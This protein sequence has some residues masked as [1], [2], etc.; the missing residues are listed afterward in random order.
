MKIP[1]HIKSM[2]VHTIVAGEHYTTRRREVIKTLLGSCVA[3]CLFDPK[4]R[5]IGMNHF[6][7][8]ADRV[9]QGDMMSSRSGFYGI[10]AME[11]LINAMLK[12]NAQRQFLQAKVFGAGSVL[13]PTD[14][15][16]AQYD[17]GRINAEFVAEFLHRE[18]IPMVVRD[19][20]GTQG[21][22]I[23]FDATDFSVYRSLIDPSQAQTVR[24]AEAQL[25]QRT[26]TQVKQEATQVLF[27]NEDEP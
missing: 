26:E 11:L 16:A 18:R 7:L 4:S 19:V 5:V 8:P 20:G 9:R 2:T 22:V 23:Y 1:E 3:V 14:G 13:T 25:L 27:W 21:R 17:V 24:A 12:K 6:L 15:Q 10:H